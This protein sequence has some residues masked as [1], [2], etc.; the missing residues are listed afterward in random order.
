MAAGVYFGERSTFNKGVILEGEPVTN[1]IAELQAAI[2][3]LQLVSKIHKTRSF[4]GEKLCQ[5]VIKVDSKYMVEGIADWLPTLLKW[6]P[7]GDEGG[8]FVVIQAT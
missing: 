1:Q 7:E 3:A 8:R 5:A 6:S 4:G 2:I